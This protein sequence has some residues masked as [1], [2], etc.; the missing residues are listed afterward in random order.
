MIKYHIRTFY[1]FVGTN[2]PISTRHLGFLAR[3]RSDLQR[4]DRLIYD[5]VV[6]L[7]NDK[8][9]LDE[10][11]REEFLPSYRVTGGRKTLCILLNNEDH[12]RFHDVLFGKSKLDTLSDDEIMAV[13][14]ALS[15]DAKDV[16]DLLGYKF[17]EPPI[18][19]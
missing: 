9:V 1:S 8:D 2:I 18:H 7:F 12:L 14:S 17:V 16:S 6:F 3:T 15:C 4:D 10:Y 13:K 19:G 5:T 11:I